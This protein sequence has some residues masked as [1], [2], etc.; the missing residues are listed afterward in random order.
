MNLTWIP[1]YE[2][3]AEDNNGTVQ[4]FFDPDTI[5]FTPDITTDWYELL[6]GSYVIIPSPGV[7]SGTANQMLQNAVMPFGMFSYATRTNDPVGV[8]Q[9]MGDTFIPVIKNPN[10]RY[11]VKVKF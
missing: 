5:V 9:V 4:T 1:V 7:M 2:S 3:F 8:K 6:Q 10:V 11:Q